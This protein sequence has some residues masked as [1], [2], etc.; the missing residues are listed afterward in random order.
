MT[1]E[2]VILLTDG[3]ASGAQTPSW[4]HR[5]DATGTTRVFEMLRRYRPFPEDVVVRGTQQSI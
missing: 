3:D 4:H 2:S 5:K 1:L